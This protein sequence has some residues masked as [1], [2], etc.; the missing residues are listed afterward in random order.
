[1]W[2]MRTREVSCGEQGLSFR[3]VIL[4][5]WGNLWKGRPITRHVRWCVPGSD[6]WAL[7]CGLYPQNTFPQVTSA[8]KYD[9]RLTP[10]PLLPTGHLTLT[11]PEPQSQIPAPGKN[12]KKSSIFKAQHFNPLQTLQSNQQGQYSHTETFLTNFLCSKVRPGRMGGAGDSAGV[13]VLLRPRG[14]CVAGKIPAVWAL[15]SSGI[16]SAVLAESPQ[17]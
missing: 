7:F 16:F 15:A 17:P 4:S 13:V 2:T 14:G 5:V 12:I 11:F 10:K 3:L 8:A 1:M 9:Q 6:R